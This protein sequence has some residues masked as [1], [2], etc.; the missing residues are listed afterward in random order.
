MAM[1]V[2]T[3]GFTRRPAADFFGVLERAAI[4]RVIDVR[5]NNRSQLAGFTKR[6]D[7]GFFVRAI[8]DAEYLEEPLL[9]PDGETLDAYRTRRIGW[10]DFA[11][12]YLESLERRKAADHLSPSLFDGPAVLLC[13]ERQPDRCHRRLAAEYLADHWGEVGVVHL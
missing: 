10:E 9:A 7:L 8:L 1:V 13:S 5:R 4:R 3:I 12:L 6:G 2:Y 11:L